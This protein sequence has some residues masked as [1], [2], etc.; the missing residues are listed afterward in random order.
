MDSIDSAAEGTLLDGMGRSAAGTQR[1]R[2]ALCRRT[3]WVIDVTSRKK[4]T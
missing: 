4:D 3:P 2:T 1:G